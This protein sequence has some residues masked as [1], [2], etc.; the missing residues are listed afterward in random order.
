M[1]CANCGNDNPPEARFCARCGTELPEI[2]AAASIP[3]TLEP[4]PPA[5][6][7]GEL[8]VI[9]WLVD[10]FV[11]GAI[12]VAIAFWSTGTGIA[13]RNESLDIAPGLLL[14]SSPWL[15]Y[16]LLTGLRG[17]TLGKM[18]MGIVVVDKQGRLPGIG[19]AAVRELLGK[20]ISTLPLLIGF[21]WM[22]FDP[23]RQGWYDK[24]AS[25]YVVRR[26]R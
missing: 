20:T 17:Q 22:F 4:A 1:Q 2:A 7:S 8:R 10:I 25:T 13:D 11:M 21:V 19:R 3:A 23:Q 14:M 6:A 15:Y 9:A 26:S 12:V 5:Y 18:L 16:W 24:L